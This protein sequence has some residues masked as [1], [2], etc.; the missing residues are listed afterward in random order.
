MTSHADHRWTPPPEDREV[1]RWRVASLFDE[2]LVYGFN[3]NGYAMTESYVVLPQPTTW[4]RAV[5]K[6]LRNTAAD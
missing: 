4:E 2:P 6:G 5:M 1:A 3:R